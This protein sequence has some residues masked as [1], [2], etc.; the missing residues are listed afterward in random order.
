MIRLETRALIRLLNLQLGIVYAKK[1]G[2]LSKYRLFFL[3]R[4]SAHVSG[5]YR[6]VYTLFRRY[7]FKN[8]PLFSSGSKRCLISRRVRGFW[9]RISNSTPNAIIKKK[10]KSF[11]LIGV[12]YVIDL[13][14]R[15]LKFTRRFLRPFGHCKFCRKQYREFEL[16]VNDLHVKVY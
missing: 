6:L 4:K 9:I 16:R 15:F 1:N 10:K 3:W 2:L 11:L 14:T 5:Y 12:M 7:V 13:T 8:I